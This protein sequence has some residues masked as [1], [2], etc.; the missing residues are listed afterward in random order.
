MYNPPSLHPAH[1]PPPAAV[2]PLCGGLL[3]VRHIP[4]QG[5]RL[6]EPLKCRS[7]TCLHT[8]THR[9]S[10]VQ[11]RRGGVGWNNYKCSNMQVLT[12][13]IAHHRLSAVLLLLLLFSKSSASVLSPALGSAKQGNHDDPTRTSERSTWEQIRALG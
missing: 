2:D 12:L 7:A 4:A 9:S 6:L 3:H 13:S 1:P 10:H 11:Q 8:H 5:H